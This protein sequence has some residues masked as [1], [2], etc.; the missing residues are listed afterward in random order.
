MD[1]VRFSTKTETV[2]EALRQRILRGEFAPGTPLM[3]EQVAQMLGVSAT[4]VREALGVLEAE[5][6]VERRPHRGVI[7]AD[8][9]PDDVADAFEFRSALEVLAMRR[10]LARLTP[11][12]LAD[13]A[14]NVREARTAM[15]RRQLNEFRVIG[16]RFHTI[17]MSAARSRTL[18]EVM[19]ILMSR[20]LLNP[21]LDRGGMAR[22]LAD[23]EELC[24][25]LESGNLAN[26][27][28]F[29]ARHMKWISS[30]GRPA[31]DGSPPNLAV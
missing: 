7:V 22:V 8:R 26:T 2:A 20:S 11:D 25:L 29:M 1:Q 27:E 16:L 30:G 10:V 5:G 23:H 19:T 24:R 15:R 4:P 17:L 3:Q 31:A 28:A 9:H 12:G 6:L 13:L 18:D 21:P 14:A